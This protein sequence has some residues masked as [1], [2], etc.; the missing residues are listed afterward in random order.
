MSA[1]LSRVTPALSAS[2]A[3]DRIIS[4]VLAILE[5]WHVPG[6]AEVRAYL[7]LRLA[8]R[9]FEIFGCLYL[10]TKHR[11]IARTPL[12]RSH[13]GGGGSHGRGRPLASGPPAR[14]GGLS[15]GGFSGINVRSQGK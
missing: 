9:C 12:P 5:R 3:E 8:E 11:V 13:H 14:A 2:D 10:D 1:V 7:R 15:R 6:S 4:A